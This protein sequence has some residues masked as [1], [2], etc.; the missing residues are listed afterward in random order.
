MQRQKICY[1]NNMHKRFSKEGF[2]LVELSFSILFIS[3]LSLAV[4][5][6]TVN[7]ISAYRRGITLNQINNMG[8]ELT[9]DMRSSVQSAQARSLVAECASFYSEDGE[10]Q[11]KCEEEGAQK[12]SSVIKTANVE[13]GDKEIKDVPVLGAFCTGSYSYIWNSGYLFNEEYNVLG[14]IKPARL[15]YKNDEGHSAEK[16]S[17]KLLKVSDEDQEVCKS[18]SGYGSG[19]V[20]SGDFDISANTYSDIE[21][22]P[23]D[24][25]T[26]DMMLALYDLS[27]GITNESATLDNSL[28]SISFILGTEQ[29]GINVNASGNYC[30]A[31]EDYKQSSVANF[32]YCAINKFNFVAQAN[33]G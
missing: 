17:F 7:A 3:V 12:F 18:A 10:A 25:M 11:K 32:D 26:G 30:V 4:A 9:D 6:L 8:M 27:V 5:L 29:G 16:N 2:T 23:E 33:G 15:I 19:N 1:N 31:P 24:I 20:F 21:E 22:D 13:V 14:G 28:Y